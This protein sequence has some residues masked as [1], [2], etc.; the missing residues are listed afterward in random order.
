M[1]IEA[2]GLSAFPSAEAFSERLGPTVLIA[3]EA[4]LGRLLGLS[5]EEA[6]ARRLSSAWALADRA[7]SVVVLEGDGCVVAAPG[8]PVAL[9][10]AASGALAT[11]G[12]G[13]VLAGLV[14]TF[15]ARGMDPLAAAAAAVLARSDAGDLAATRVGAGYTVAGDIIQALPEA[16]APPRD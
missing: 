16:L 8:G 1:V 7:G 10:P 6:G 3:A 4:G 9:G 12:T 13:S 15:L 11:N 2:G 14:G 5:A